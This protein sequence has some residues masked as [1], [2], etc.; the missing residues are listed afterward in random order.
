MKQTLISDVVLKLCQLTDGARTGSHVNLSLYRL[1][2]VVEADEPGLATKLNIDT[3]LQQMSQVCLSIREMR[4][5][6]IAHRDWGH[7][8]KP[9][10]VTNK[11]EIVQALR[12][13]SRIMNAVHLHYDNTE[14]NYEPYPGSVDGHRL[15]SHLQTYVEMLGE[16]EGG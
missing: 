2:D 1:R 16:T 5:R 12:L 7:R 13:A 15:I 9:A 8:A 4:N 14:S 11:D 3:M 6:L 10:P